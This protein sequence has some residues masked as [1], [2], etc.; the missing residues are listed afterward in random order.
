MLDW[1]A[2]L[3]HDQENQTTTI[4]CARPVL[5]ESKEIPCAREEIPAG[6]LF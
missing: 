1:P 6:A 3:C 2:D 5:C 4:A